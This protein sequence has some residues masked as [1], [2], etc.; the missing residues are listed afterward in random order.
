MEQYKVLMKADFN[1]FHREAGRGQ[2]SRGAREARREELCVL[3]SNSGGEIALKCIPTIL[4]P[5]KYFLPQSEV[6][7]EY[8]RKTGRREATLYSEDTGRLRRAHVRPGGH[9]VPEP[10]V[11]GPRGRQ[12]QR[13]Q[14]EDRAHGPGV[15]RELR[16][17]R[18]LRPHGHVSCRAAATTCCSRK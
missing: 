18:H 9:T 12:L 3:G 1:A 17:V 6:L 11:P 5:K 13:A 14:E 8:D 7:A 2:E 15:R 16:R 4:P 10:G